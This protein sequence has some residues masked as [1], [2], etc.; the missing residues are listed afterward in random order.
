MGAINERIFRLLEDKKLTA[1]G[2]ADHIGT[3]EGVVSAWK[4]RGTEPKSKYIQD[5]ADYLG[6]SEKYL[7]S[8]KEL[9]DTEEV[10]E[11]LHKDPKLRMLFDAADGAS[12]EDLELAAEMLKKMKK[13]S[14][15]DD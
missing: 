4:K 6:V 7:M 1:R 5:I 10:A 3:T 12:P 8:G 14:G 15:Y 11:R 13:N 2:M 9:T